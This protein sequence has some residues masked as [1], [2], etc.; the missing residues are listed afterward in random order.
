LVFLRPFSFQQC[1]RFPVS[2]L[3]APV[4]LNGTSAMMPHHGGRIEP[5]RPSLLL[6]PPAHIHIVSRGLKLDIKSSDN[7]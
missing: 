3:L 6:Q 7:L 4:C 5:Q 1:F 2:F